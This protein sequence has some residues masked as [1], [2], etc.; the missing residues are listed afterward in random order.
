MKN[1][2]GAA[3]IELRNSLWAQCEN[4]YIDMISISRSDECL[5]WEI[6]VE[7]GKFRRKELDAH[8]AAAEKLGRHRALAEVCRELDKII[9]ADAMLAEDAEHEAAGKEVSK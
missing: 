5:G 9:N 7:L 8:N 2:G 1:D 4:A 6:K 3:L